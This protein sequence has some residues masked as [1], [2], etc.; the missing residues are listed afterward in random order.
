MGY[1][2]VIEDKTKI[3]PKLAD[4]QQ[5]NIAQGLVEEKGNFKRIEELK[6]V[7]GIGNATFE[8]CKNFV[9]LTD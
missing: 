8:K 7:N 6:N 1:K 9:T 4:Y 5:K 3:K 2:E